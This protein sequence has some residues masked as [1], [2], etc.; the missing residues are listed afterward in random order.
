MIIGALTQ[1]P[2]H[3]TSSHDRGAGFVQ[4]K[5]VMMDL[6]LADL[7]KVFR[8]TQHAGRRSTYLDMRA[9][10]YWLQLELRIERRNF[11]D[12]DQGHIEQGRYIFDRRLG[13]PAILFLRAHQK[14]NNCRLFTAFWIFL[15]CKLCP[16][17]V[18]AIE[19]ERCWLDVI[20]CETADGH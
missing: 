11:E 1:A 9:G 17:A 5:L 8:A 12:T 2:R 4:L 20:F 7:L 10:A 14:R 15:D 3:S 18:F 16:S 6:V 13:N 19:R